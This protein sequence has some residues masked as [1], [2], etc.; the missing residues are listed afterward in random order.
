[1]APTRDAS[2]VYSYLLTG[3]LL[4]SLSR[5][6]SRSRVGGPLSRQALRVVRDF[7]AYYKAT[8]EQAAEKEPMRPIPIQTWIKAIRFATT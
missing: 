2:I 5:A 8:K 3:W 7:F 1:V 6:V 4:P